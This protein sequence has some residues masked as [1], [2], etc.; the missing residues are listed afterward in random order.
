MGRKLGLSTTVVFLSLVVW[1]WVWGSVGMLL[2][3]PLTM[4]LKIML[5]NSKEYSVVATLLDS[6]GSE[7]E[8]DDEPPPDKPAPATPAE[9]WTPRED[10]S[11]DTQRSMTPTDSQPPVA[12]EPPASAPSEPPS[13]RDPD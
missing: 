8:E 10:P 7:E 13:S 1:G 5:E 2:S 9:N 6:G 11:P 12:P 4:V 3:V